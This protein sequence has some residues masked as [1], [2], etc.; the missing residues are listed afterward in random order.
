MTVLRLDRYMDLT[1]KRKKLNE[2]K[3][4]NSNGSPLNID[5]RPDCY[6]NDG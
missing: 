1:Q 2:K 3:C 4:S 5:K 6:K